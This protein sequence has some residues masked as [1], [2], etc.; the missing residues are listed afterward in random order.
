MHGL[1]M[2]DEG[3]LC[4]EHDLECLQLLRPHPPCHQ[5]ILPAQVST[6]TCHTW[7]WPSEQ[8]HTCHWEALV[9]YVKDQHHSAGAGHAKSKKEVVGVV[10]I[11]ETTLLKRVNEFSTT[12]AGGLTVDEFEAHTQAADAA[13]VSL[14]GCGSPFVIALRLFVQPAWWLGDHGAACLAS[15]FP[16]PQR[17][18]LG[19]T[20]QVDVMIAS[21]AGLTVTPEGTAP[22]SGQLCNGLMS[23]WLHCNWT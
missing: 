12:E 7:S 22:P 20:V 4:S 3:L 14:A 11:G 6:D 8:Q 1:E 10:H 17:Q 5:D 2:L 9:P 15:H 23:Q 19:A 13:L 18:C 21:G 16:A